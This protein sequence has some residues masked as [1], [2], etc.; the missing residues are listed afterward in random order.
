M[1]KLDVYQTLGVLMPGYFFS[2]GLYLIAKKA[3][4]EIP[5]EISSIGGSI[6]LLVIS[7]IIGQI[8]Q[9][10]GNGFEWVWRKI[11]KAPTTRVQ[12]GD[13]KILSE[14]QHQ[15]LIEAM[16]RK[17]GLPDTDVSQ[18]PKNEW[19]S[20]V[21]LVASAVRQAKQMEQVDIFSAHYGMLR[22]VVA[23]TF[24]LILASWLL[25]KEH[26]CVPVIILI[27]FGLLALYRM[28]R[29]D[30]NYGKELFRQ[31]LLIARLDKDT[32][33]HGN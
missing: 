18:M 16:R 8:V 23:T 12:K 6:T 30:K 29:F 31:F 33:S 9:A 4:V 25:L 32:A 2:I 5:L 24:L 11:R 26:A 19:S 1:N 17:V 15:K 22:G 7:Y 3:G 10:F 20:Y 13:T 28:D 27:A 21:G 14:G